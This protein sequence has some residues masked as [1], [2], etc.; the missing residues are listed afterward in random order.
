MKLRDFFLSSPKLATSDLLFPHQS[1]SHDSQFSHN[2]PDPSH[3]LSFFGLGFYPIFRVPL[4][5]TC[6][7]NFHC[8]SLTRM[9]FRLSIS[10]ACFR[11]LLPLRLLELRILFLLNK[12]LISLLELRILFVFNSGFSSSISLS[13]S[14]NS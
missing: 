3:F 1:K 5:H 4:T 12:L 14:S 8:L 13:F 6:H 2:I 10:T 7:I 9:F 11:I